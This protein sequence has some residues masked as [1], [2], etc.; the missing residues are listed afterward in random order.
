MESLGILPSQLSGSAVPAA[1]AALGPAG[2]RV[3]FETGLWQVHLKT[4]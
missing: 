2:G 4:D 3:S 1:A